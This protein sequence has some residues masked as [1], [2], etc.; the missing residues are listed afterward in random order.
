MNRPNKYL[1][2]WI[3]VPLLLLVL[4]KLHNYKPVA[5][6]HINYTEFLAMLDG[7]YVT[8]VMIQGQDLFV[9]D[10]NSRQL[11]VFVPPDKD[12]IGILK[13]KGVFITA[14]PPA[15]SAWYETFFVS[16]VPMILLVGVWIFFMR[17]M[18]AGGGNPLSFGKSRARLFS[19]KTNKVT[20]ED[21]AGIDEVKEELGE[22]IESPIKSNFREGLTVVEYF[23]STH[24][25]RKGLADTA[26][27]TADAGYLTRRLVDVAQ[28]VVVT[29]EDCGTILGLEMSAL[30]EGEDI[31]EPLRDRIV[32]TAALE[33]VYDPI[34]GELLMKSGELIEEEAADAVEDAGI[35]MVKIR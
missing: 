10:E 23:I 27:K 35:Q 4:Y 17:R 24:G 26:L 15:E 19:D 25:A 12:L 8:E 31:I 18:Q 13:Q 2:L 1:A 3:I 7:G 16:V 34:D 5:E 11:R 9:T 22:I 33:D 21:V 6:T 14:K 32:G 20:F 30:K 28:D 29:N